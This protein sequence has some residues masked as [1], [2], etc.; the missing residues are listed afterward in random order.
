M[1]AALAAVALLAACAAV[2]ENGRTASSGAPET[3]SLAGE[4]LHRPELAPERRAELERD[5]A[6]ARAALEADPTDEDALVW[7]GRRLAY[8]GRYRDAVEHSTAALA[9]HPD[10]AE[11]L[12]HRGHR[13]LTLRELERAESD[14]ER[15]A[16]LCAGRPDELE[17]DGAPNA[18]GVPR[19]TLQ[20]NVW[21]HLA[22]AR[23][24]RG[25]FEGA[26]PAWSR[27]AELST[28]DDMLCAAT[29][30]LVL[31]LL[32]LDRAGEA[33]LA[34][35]PIREDMEILENH[36]YHALLLLFRGERTPEQVLG[37]RADDESLP[38]L[39]LATRG[40]GVARW[41]AAQDRED[42]A[43]RLLERVVAETAWPAFGHLAAEAGLARGE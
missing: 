3:R 23:Y 37:G 12:R 20:T 34:L 40:Y 33:R 31:T 10:S 22:L 17:P 27:C 4:P 14:L 43:H 29:Y 6:D 21:Y 24:V 11:L 9:I 7:V 18:A 13:W 28:N 38:G 2:D 42:E 16:E 30:W 8:L 5:L 35:E 26:L 19:S 15:A 1:R 39:E 32:R 36:A 41:L 25:D